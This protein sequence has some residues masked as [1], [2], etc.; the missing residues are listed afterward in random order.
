[1]SPELTTAEVTTEFPAHETG[2]A[3]SSSGAAVAKPGGSGSGSR[4]PGIT[5]PQFAKLVLN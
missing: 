1:M 4:C 3:A 2:A 5:G